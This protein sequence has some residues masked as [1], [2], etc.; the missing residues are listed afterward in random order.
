M[1]KRHFA[2]SEYHL[3][4][5]EK[6]EREFAWDG[7]DFENWQAGLRRRFKELL[8]GFPAEQSPLHIEET[9]H[10][11]CEGFTR[12]RLVFRAEDHADVP[13][14]LL[15]PEGRELPR[16]AMICLQGHAPGMHIS[17]GV[18]HDEH[19]RD[20]VAGDRDFALQAVRE[21]FVALAVEQRCFGERA[22]TNQEM[23]WDHPCLDAV[24][25]ALILGQTLI[26]ERVRDVCRA[27]DLLEQ[28]PEVDADHIACMGN[29]GGGKVSF[30]AACVEPRIELAV[31]SCTFAQYA[32]SSM[33]FRHC[34]DTYIPG[35][36]KVAEMGEIGGLIVPRN[37]IIVSGEH[38]AI[39]P[40]ES[41]R[42][43]F[44]QAR[45]IFA[46]AGCAE[47]IRHVVGPEGHRFYADLA[48]PVIHELVPQA[49]M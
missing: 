33:R 29:S 22:E 21:G 37:L 20:L 34:G 12:V 3:H 26:G 47:N 19:E 41:A 18:T 23:R 42:A 49:T 39:F 6:T 1:P 40:V 28:R 10:V 27:V 15:V 4:L 30:Y 48:W 13:A 7:Q 5:M 36:L 32:D 44:R 45:E 17:V 8:G 24:F 2:P 11:E 35:I 14:Y 25:H 38:D 46:A 43:G 9:E 16:P 31:A